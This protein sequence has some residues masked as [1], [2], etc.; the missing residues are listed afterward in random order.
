MVH[1]A[2]EHWEYGYAL[3]ADGDTGM[4]IIGNGVSIRSKF[5]V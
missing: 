5:V 3:Y 4:Q 1:S 2:E